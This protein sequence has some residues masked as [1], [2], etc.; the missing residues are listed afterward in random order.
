MS[1][2]IP[3]LKTTMESNVKSAYY[4]GREDTLEQ[5]KHRPAECDETK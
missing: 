3:S 5:C 1:I 4:M 2:H